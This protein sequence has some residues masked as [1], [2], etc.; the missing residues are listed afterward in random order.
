MSEF[1]FLFRGNDPSGRSPEQMQ[2]Y[3]R[4]RRLRSFSTSCADLA[5]A[6]SKKYVR[7]KAPQTF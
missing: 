7:F 4:R 2:Q 3:P 5:W 6:K 1:V